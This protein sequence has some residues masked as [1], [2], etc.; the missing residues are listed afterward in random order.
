[1]SRRP[2]NSNFYGQ[3]KKFRASTSSAKAT[4]IESGDKHN[5]D[6]SPVSNAPS[7]IE[8]ALL[9]LK[10]KFPVEKFEGRLPPVLLVHQIY[11]I[12]KCK[13]SVDREIVGIIPP[14]KYIVFVLHLDNLW[15]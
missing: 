14:F 3:S 1:M 5:L 7:D 6:V 12:I 15:K 8:A 10:S 4:A 2:S 9:Y 13:T 11:S